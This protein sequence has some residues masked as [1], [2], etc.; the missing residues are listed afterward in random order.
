[1]D[2][3]NLLVDDAAFTVRRCFV[4]SMNNAVYLLTDRASGEQLLVDAADD[5]TAIN[6]LIADGATDAASPT[7][8]ETQDAA[9]VTRIVTTHAHWDHTRATA[10]LASQ[11]GA[12]VAIGREDAAQLRSERGVDADELLDHGDTVAVGALTLEVI[13][14]RGHTPGSVALAL[15]AAETQPALVFT[16]DSL[17][18]G[19]VGNTNGDPERFA[20]LFRDVTER[21]FDRFDDETR[22]FP[23]HGDPTTL[24][25]ERASL[26]EWQSRGW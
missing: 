11:T 2:A 10:E 15:P 22:V 17:F 26:P 3:S 25:D 1:M 20:Q 6:A 13:A 4:S 8:A 7:I 14:L 18:P 9:H 21:I 19:G 5:P 16:G 24:G 23:G 12:P